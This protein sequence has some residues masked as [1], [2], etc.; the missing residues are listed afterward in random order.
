MKRMIAL[1]L[2]AI[3]TLITGL[4]ISQYTSDLPASEVDAAMNARPTDFIAV[5]NNRVHIR[6][7]G[8]AGN[9]PLI[10][11]HG[12]GASLHAWDQITPDLT[13]QFR[14]IAIDLPFH[15]LTGPAN[16]GKCSPNDVAQFVFAVMDRLDV[17]TAYLAG[18]SWGGQ[19]ALEMALSRPDRIGGLVLIDAAGLDSPPSQAARLAENPIGRYVLTHLTSPFMVR[20]TL[21]QTMYDSTKVTD[22]LVN[23]FVL[24]NRREGNR[25]GA[26]GC[27][28]ASRSALR[29][30]QD[31]Y[32]QIT[33]PT[34]IIW[35]RHDQLIP[36]ANA[37]RFGEQI[38]DAAKHIYDYTGHL[39]MQ[40]KPAAV[41]HDIV[42]FLAP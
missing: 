23:Q 42:K 41:A 28:I 12:M 37:D 2:T 25:A 27:R 26:L 11:L 29:S 31:A 15:G 22:D 38:R 5:G 17:P 20:R 32:S 4:V 39:P 35:G 30:T 16:V 40:E 1:I 24:L 3:V 18:N 9:P 7:S 19:I 6:L 10:L 14:V 8:D 21:R 13:K 34:L 33:Q 36:V